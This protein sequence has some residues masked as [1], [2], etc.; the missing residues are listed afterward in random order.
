M[1]VGMEKIIRIANDEFAK[2]LPESKATGV[3]IE[4]IEELSESGHYLVTI[5]YWARDNKPMPKNLGI[6]VSM[7]IAM[8]RSA[9]DLYNPWRKKYKRVVVDP[10]QGKAVAIR[11]YE[12]PLGVS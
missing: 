5:S 11:M 3:E 7:N 8:G 10:T 6:D 12:P 2:I 4:E 9:E 1:P